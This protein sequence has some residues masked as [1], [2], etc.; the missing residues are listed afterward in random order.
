M[1]NC[2]SKMC[3]NNRVYYCTTGPDHSSPLRE[4]VIHVDCKPPPGN[5]VWVAFLI[6][7]VG[8]V[9]SLTA[10]LII[11]NTCYLWTI[12]VLMQSCPLKT[13]IIVLLSVPS[14]L[15]P[16]ILCDTLWRRDTGRDGRINR[17]SVSC[18]GRSGNLNLSSS[19]PG[20]VKPMTLKLI[21]VA[22]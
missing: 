3:C 10:S 6:S 5:Q 16:N 13:G 15:S 11:Q 7:L 1:E 18:A 20:W 4:R 22:S 9:S 21:R 19:N 8:N 12:L 2:A 14:M 17:A